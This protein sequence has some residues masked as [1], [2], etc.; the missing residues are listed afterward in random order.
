MANKSGFVDIFRYF[1]LFWR[2]LLLPAT[3]REANAGFRK[4][5]GSTRAYMIFNAILAMFFGA[6]VPAALLVVLLR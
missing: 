1:V 3:R 5:D 4:S 2:Y 6:I